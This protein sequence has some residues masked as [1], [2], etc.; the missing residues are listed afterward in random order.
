[1]AGITI[2]IAQARLTA[3]LT[4]EE[5]LLTGHLSVK[6]NNKEFRRSE[7]SQIQEG[8]KLWNNRVES[9][10]NTATGRSRTLSGVPR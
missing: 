1:M 9:L 3:Y 2:E 6:I 10:T 7:L 5:A 4:A 8:I